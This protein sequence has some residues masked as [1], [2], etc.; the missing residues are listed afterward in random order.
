[1]Q[2]S[3]RKTVLVSLWHLL[4]CIILFVNLPVQASFWLDES[5]SFW[6]ASSNSVS[7]LWSKV[8]NFQGQSPLYFLFL[9]VVLALPGEVETLARVPS[10]LASLG[11]GIITFR[12]FKREMPTIAAVSAS[13]FTLS[14][15]PFLQ[16][17]VS[18]RPYGLALLCFVSSFF[19]LSRTIVSL[20]DQFI[21]IT[22]LVAC[23]YLQPTF[24]TGVFALLLVYV[25]HPKFLLLAGAAFLP[26]IWMLAV[27]MKK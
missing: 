10:L 22:L 16:S 18:A 25:R 4:F 2:I 3:N 23:A 11:V 13:I 24:L 1:M 21:A 7:E 19:L 6:I 26:L 5:I 15:D 20:T 27:N 14:S 8:L 17:F 12:I 9:R